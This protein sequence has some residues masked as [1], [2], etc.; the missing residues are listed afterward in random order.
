VTEEAVREEETVVIGSVRLPA[1]QYEWLRAEA[2]RRHVPVVS[3]LRE[4]VAA[5]IEAGRED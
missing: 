3:L 1:S 4:A 2:Y 5:K